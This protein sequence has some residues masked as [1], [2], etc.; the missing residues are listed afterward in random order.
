MLEVSVMLFRPT[1]GRTGRTALAGRARR[2][3]A[4]GA[5]ALVAVIGILAGVA[6]SPPGEAA[7]PS[8]PAIIKGDIDCSGAVAAL[9]A[10][11]ALQV[12]AGLVDN[13]G[14]LEAGDVN[15]DDAINA[16]DALEI[17]RHIAG[18]PPGNIPEGCPPIG[19]AGELP[20]L[21]FEVDESVE[22]QRDGVAPRDDNQP[23]PVAALVDDDGMQSV[24]VENELIIVTDD[25]DALND[26]I[27]R[28]DGELLAS[29]DPS[30]SGFDDLPSIH[31][32]RVDASAADASQLAEDLRTVQGDSWGD[33]A[34]SS[35]EGLDLLAAAAEENVGGTQVSPN[36]VMEGATYDQRE[37][38]ES[39]T[40]SGGFTPNPFDW[41]YMDLGSNQDIGVAEAWRALNASAKLSNK[42]KITILDGG[43]SP[44]SDF[45][46]GYTILGGANQP[47]PA[48]CTAGSSCPWHGTTVTAS[49]MGVPD[50]GFGVAGPAGPIANATL[51]QSP[52]LDF[53]D[54]LEYIFL[55]IP[56]AT[57][58]RPHIVNISAGVGIPREVC[59]LG[60]CALMDG[61]TETLRFANIL[62]F[63]AAGNDN[64]DVDKDRCINLLLGE[65]CY[66]K[67]VHIPCEL[68]DVICVG[69]LDWDSN[70]RHPNSN[71]G[72]KSSGDT[73][74]IYGPYVQF[75][76]I[77]PDSPSVTRGPCGTSCATPFVAGVTALIKAANPGLGASALE[78]RLMTHAHTGSS[79]PRVR[80]WVNAYD[81][82]IAELGGN[83][84]PEVELQ[85]LDDGDQ[86]P[87]SYGFD[88]AIFATVTDAEDRPNLGT[89]YTGLP[90]VTWM[91]SKDGFLGNG[92]FLPTGKDL[93][94]GDH[95]ITVRAT[96]SL[97]A[98]V[99]DSAAVTIYNA[100][101][102][103][104]LT[105]PMDQEL[106]YEGEIINFRGISFDIN[107][108]GAKLS[109]S[110][111]E[112]F[113]SPGVARTP[114]G[115][116]VSLGAGHDLQA[117]LPIGTHTITL[118][119][120]DS[121]GVQAQESVVVVVEEAP[122]NLRPNVTITSPPNGSGIGCTETIMLQGTATDPEDGPLP[123][124]SLAWYKTINGATS[125][126]GVGA[127][128]PF[129]F[130]DSFGEGQ[131][132]FT[133][134]LR[135]TDSQ[136]AS[137]TD[138]ISMTWSC[139][140]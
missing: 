44:N 8:G 60:I 67:T 23:R 68:N 33:F 127:S 91:S 120:T 35:E 58:E 84:P 53:F 25:L 117:T 134:T 5:V 49:A 61:L 89:P 42:V 41:P 76:G 36:W 69:G 63:A 18:L 114:Q 140:L 88:T 92:P 55:S 59:L 85:G 115:D 102:T 70:Q 66:E 20:P 48:S 26:F 75:R 77:T 34:V 46:A 72:S 110:Q 11:G 112:W 126:I 38:M 86:I 27:E 3:P 71:Y 130:T 119:G 50:N 99:V 113:R 82:V 14:C 132:M 97:G 1:D 74:D 43:F 62:I 131:V 136:G 28:W 128:V 51:V 24:F 54:I 95:V 4:V 109:D 107:E 118:I 101:P 123:G 30:D 39:P 19:A 21:E 78:N 52:D 9:D 96:D 138:T 94:Y 135:A 100:P 65:I 87:G 13:P 73:V 137:R 45:P 104:N 116:M 133:I 29:I 7:S 129:Q 125:L 111:M 47:N 17:L 37:L 79:D 12:V 81:A 121:E 15:C 22:P 6:W 139:I 64:T 83:H 10:L 124:N 103:V 2:L 80:R 16:T 98:T 93:T 105:S 31:L 57:A 90:V 108:Q 32:V 40:G 56:T 122:E 106:L